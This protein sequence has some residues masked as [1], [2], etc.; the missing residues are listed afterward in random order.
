MSLEASLHILCIMLKDD[1]QASVKLKLPGSKFMNLLQDASLQPS[2]ARSPK[3]RYQW[4]TES[5]DVLQNCL[6]NFEE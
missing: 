2:S 3:Q 6:K 1:V 5:T 4:P